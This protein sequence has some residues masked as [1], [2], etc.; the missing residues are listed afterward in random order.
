MK[1]ENTPGHRVTDLWVFVSID[2]DGDEGILAV[3]TPDGMLPL[4]SSTEENLETMRL[5]AAIMNSE[6]ERY[7]LRHFT[8]FDG[9]LAEL[10]PQQ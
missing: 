10:F 1:K 7:E 4:V 8:Q 9:D 3:Q 6:G 5:L 2:A